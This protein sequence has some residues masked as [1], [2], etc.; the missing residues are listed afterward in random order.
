VFFSSA[1]GLHLRVDRPVPGLPV[2]SESSGSD[3]EVRLGDL[4]A[5][6][7]RDGRA[8]FRCSPWHTGQSGADGQP[9]WTITESAGGALF[10][11]RFR[12][13]TE[14]LLDRAAS[15]VSAV[16][17]ASLTLEDVA[18]YLLGPVMGFIL[19]LRGRICL[20]SSAV[21]FAGRAIALVGPSGAGKSTLAAALARQGLPVVTDDIVALD[22]AKDKAKFVVP[23]GYPRLRLWPDS[24]RLL[25]GR[26]DVLPRL[27]PNWDKCYADLT[28]PGYLFQ[29]EP[30]PLGA[31]YLLGGPERSGG[32]VIEPVS[33][34][35][36]MIALTA[37][38]Y[39][40]LP[41]QAALASAFGI[42]GR[43]VAQVPVRRVWSLEN[44]LPPDRLG[45]LLLADFRSVLSES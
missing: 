42:L 8:L 43:I 16:W 36:A 13:G 22:V 11:M 9:N 21:A 25:L 38:R 6:P 4:P 34:P 10:R 23:P 37:H 14:F 40:P 44:P 30:V 3:I 31:V 32:L 39:F 28:G 27:T 19:A 29:R 45:E 33:S 7:A 1:F 12:D 17:P 18:T 2:D 5:L 26:S 35:S 24:V 20:H 15:R 41:G